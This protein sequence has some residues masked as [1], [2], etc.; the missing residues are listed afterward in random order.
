MYVYKYVSMYVCVHVCVNVFM[1][2][3]KCCGDD[4]SHTPG[5]QVADR[6][7]GLQIWRLAANILNKQSRTKPL[8]ALLQGISLSGH[9][10]RVTEDTFGK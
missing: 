2:V 4:H 9:P 6:G 3:L 7:I 5:P 8:V 1:Y 10:C